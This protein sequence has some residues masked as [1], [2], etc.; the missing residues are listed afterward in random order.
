[1]PGKDRQDTGT[2]VL[3]KFEKA[4]AGNGLPPGDVFD[5]LP[6]SA[7]G[8]VPAAPRQH[9]TVLLPVDQTGASCH[10]GRRNCSCNEVPGDRGEMVA[11]PVV[12]TETLF[13]K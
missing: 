3:N 5:G 11:K 10:A 4:A 12:E 9:D 13:G 1:M 7:D 6:H 8:L 2:S